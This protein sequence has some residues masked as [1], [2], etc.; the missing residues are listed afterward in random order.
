M[1]SEIKREIS[2][3][4]AD[5]L[6]GRVTIGGET[7]PSGYFFMNA[8]NEYWKPYDGDDSTDFEIAGK[9]KMIKFNRDKVQNEIALNFLYPDHAEKL[10]TDIEYYLN[11][12]QKA[13]PFYFLDLDDERERCRRI[14]STENIASIAAYLRERSFFN[15]EHD[16]GWTNHPLPQAK[17]IER[18]KT[19][20][21]R[22]QEFIRVVKFY[23]EMGQGMANAHEIGRLF[24][25][26]LDSPVKRTES[27]LMAIAMDCIEKYRPGRF[28]SFER[29]MRI[30]V[31]YVPVPKNKKLDVFEVSR[32]MT[33][34][35]FGDF[36][37]ADFFEG[38]HVGH[39]LL[40]CGV[41]KQY[42]LQKSAHRRKYCTGY[43]PNDPKG[44]SCIAFA[45]RNNRLSKESAADH[46][47]KIPYNRRR[48]TIDKHLQRGKITA[49]QADDAK[50]HIE[51][52]LYKALSD[53][54]YFLSDYENDMKQD[55]VYSAVG[56]KL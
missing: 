8:M 41:C 24:V 42:F 19:E 50:R 23:D 26:A 49:E 10:Y 51:D 13:K 21:N 3:F 4:T 32:R 17:D 16:S 30:N 55:S 56:I 45:A 37:F 33:F 2:C 44:R 54:A 48:G 14:F 53:N 47:V 40:R 11:N 9:L 25:S 15:Y 20:E 6:D 31:E 22:L 29:I 43:A 5:F 7:F 28:T 1:P 34:E 38:L 46:P 36:L 52:L 39:Y 27:N 35:R 18:F 12:I